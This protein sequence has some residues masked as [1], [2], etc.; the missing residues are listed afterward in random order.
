MICYICTNQEFSGNLRKD[1]TAR[2]RAVDKV[3]VTMI[4]LHNFLQK[5]IL[6]F[7][8]VSWICQKLV[9]KKF[10]HDLYQKEIDL[11]AR[12][13][14]REKL[15]CIQNSLYS[16]IMADEYTQIENQERVPLCLSIFSYNPCK[17]DR[18]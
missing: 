3:A 5:T 9:T 7:E 10:F 6:K 2:Q 8:Y 17:F 4:V 1:W 18:R 16:G 13:V 12:K 11:M 15:K 14:L